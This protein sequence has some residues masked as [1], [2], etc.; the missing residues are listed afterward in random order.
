MTDNSDLRAELDALAQR[1]GTLEDS[2][3][4]RKLHYAYGYYIDFCQY[5]EVVQL[6]ADDGEVIFLS[7]IYKGKEGVARLYK[8]WFQNYF[9]HGKPGPEDGFLLDHFQMQD[10]ITVAPD[11]KTAKGRFRA[12]LMGGVHESR[13]YKPEGLPEQFYEAGIYENDYVCVD[14]VWKIKRLD[15]MVQWQAE[16]EKGWSKTEAHLQPAVET[17][18]K[19]PL[20]PDELL[21]EPR[22]TWP[23]RHDVPYHYAHPVMGRAYKP[24]KE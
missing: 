21:P 14:G 5:D 19:N 7:G 17:Y 11:R 12:V 2:A 4:I 1:V 18:P 22:L 13:E 15:Y 20:G 8:T 10:I 6:F 3:A 9:T 16:Y 23:N 24:F